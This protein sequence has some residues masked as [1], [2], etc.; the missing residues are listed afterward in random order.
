[1]TTGDLHEFEDNELGASNLFDFS[2]SPDTLQ[3]LDAIGTNDQKS[4]LNPQELT[5]GPLPDSPNG[6]Y[7]DSS[8]ESASSSKRTGSSASSKTP[9]ATADKAMNDG[10][11]MR[12]D[13]GNATFNTFDDD[14]HA[15]T[16]GR[17]A[18]PSAM[19]GLY[20]FGDQDDSFMDRSFDFDSASASPEALS[21]G[22][23]NLA[24]PGMPT[25][26]TNTPHKANPNPQAKNGAHKKQNSVRS[27]LQA[28]YELLL[29][30]AT[31]RK[32]LTS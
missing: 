32:W 25:I 29:D 10:T 26:K 24:S 1:M 3:S 18:D 23:S 2:N 19:D 4:F 28:I 9:V 13:W 5:A 14:E 22:Q 6:S 8:S 17:D 27:M 15:F 31:S 7:Q 30:F 11:D 21:T 12:M 20:A 16:F